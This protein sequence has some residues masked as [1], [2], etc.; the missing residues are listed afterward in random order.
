MGVTLLYEKIRTIKYCFYF[1]STYKKPKEAEDFYSVEEHS[2]HFYST[3]KKP[4]NVI[5]PS[6]KIG[7][8]V[9]IFIRLIKSQSIPKTVFQSDYW[10]FPFLFDL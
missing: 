2:F 5:E 6:V 8:Q 9:S 4:K 1:Y 7:V 10:K 3:Y